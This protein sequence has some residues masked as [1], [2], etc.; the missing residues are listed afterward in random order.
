MNKVE[1]EAK[2]VTIE[3]NEQLTKQKLREVTER[4]QRREDEF[5]KMAKMKFKLSSILKERD[6]TIRALKDDLQ[7]NKDHQNEIDA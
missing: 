4:M 7:A 5:N 6:S 1:N 3:S 2:I